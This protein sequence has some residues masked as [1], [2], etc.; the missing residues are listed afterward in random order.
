M[1][2]I[3]QIQISWNKRKSQWSYH[4]NFWFLECLSDEFLSFKS[5]EGN[6]WWAGEYSQDNRSGGLRQWPTQFHSNLAQSFTCRQN[7][8]CSP[9][10]IQ[11]WEFALLYAR[12][13]DRV[14]DRRLCS[15]F[16]GNVNVIV[17][18]WFYTKFE[19]RKRE[20]E[21]VATNLYLIRRVLGRMQ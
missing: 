9:S 11:F 7:C 12:S 6:W 18:I 5:I 13:P 19:P 21:Q 14:C 17:L 3:H 20:T 16:L 2:P 15:Q 1:S 10:I 8:V 4:I